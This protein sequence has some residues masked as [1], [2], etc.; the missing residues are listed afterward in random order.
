MASLFTVSEGDAASFQQQ[1]HRLI[2]EFVE[3]LLNLQDREKERV[4]QIFDKERLVYSSD[5]KQVKDE[6][7][8]LTGK[9]LHPEIIEQLEQMRETPVGGII[10]GA[11]NKRVELDG[12]IVLQSDEQGMVIVNELREPQIANNEIFQPLKE[13]NLAGVI[14]S[15][16]GK[17]SEIAEEDKLA[18]NYQLLPNFENSQIND[19]VASVRQGLQSKDYAK[20]EEAM[21]EVPYPVRKSAISFLSETERQEAKKLKEHFMAE[22]L[23]GIRTEIKDEIARPIQR[24]NLGLEEQ[25]ENLERGSE[26]ILRSLEKLPDSPTKKV[27]SSYTQDIQNL[28]QIFQAQA[29]QINELQRSVRE[30]TQQLTQQRL[31]QPENKS[32]WDE[33]LI[34][35][36]SAWEKWNQ[37]LRQHQAA[38]A[39][40]TLYANQ[41]IDGA[42]VLQ[43][44]EYRIEREGKNYTLS[45]NYG[46]VLMRFKSTKLG[47]RVDS[48]SIQM[49]SNHYQDIELLKT[50]QSKNEQ[51]DG[52]FS[53][54]GTREGIKEFDRYMRSQTITSALIEYA[55]K[56]GK[57]VMLDGEFSYKWKAKLNGEVKIYAK[58]GRGLIL[59]QAGNQMISRMTSQ[60]FGYFEE[61]LTKLRSHETS[62]ITPI[63]SRQ[64]RKEN[65]VER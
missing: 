36:S 35:F 52:A 40:R 4:V 48:E 42:K 64:R 30:L 6:L 23:A 17:A 5:S 29:N 58:D 18:E 56:L 54:P 7:S 51:P 12:R 61:A 26:R 14:N 43:L 22:G 39:I 32:W 31:A 44:A 13:E 24:Q 46:Q 16:D 11:R 8:G 15:E 60:D 62:R 45:D 25:Q 20:I 27:I 3:T 47:V 55:T 38:S 57:D 59:A 49:K 21:Y 2:E 10:E 1:Y 9:L 37:S 65:D 53:R 50:Q 63:S 34:T 28:L 33:T 41:T 19:L